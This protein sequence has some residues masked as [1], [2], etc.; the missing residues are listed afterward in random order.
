MKESY[1]EGVAHHHGPR[2]SA[3][4]A[5]ISCARDEVSMTDGV[6][7]SWVLSSESINPGL[8]ALLLD[9]VGEMSRPKNREDVGEPAES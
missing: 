2:S 8:P 7:V 1:M 9:V 3:A 6:R 5:A 4:D